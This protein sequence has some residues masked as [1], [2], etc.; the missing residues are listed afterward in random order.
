MKIELRHCEFASWLDGYFL[1][2]S[3]T[4]CEYQEGAGL[5]FYCG[6]IDATAIRK[7]KEEQ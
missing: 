3:Q 1:C 5:T 4:E 6:R 7:E 2:N